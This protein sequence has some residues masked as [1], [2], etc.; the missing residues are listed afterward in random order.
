MYVNM[1]NMPISCG[2][3]MYTPNRKYIYTYIYIYMKW[4]SGLTPVVATAAAAAAV[5]SPF[6]LD[7]EKCL[8]FISN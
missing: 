4:I 1:S 8:Q 6:S 3:D 7:T 2:V 5:S